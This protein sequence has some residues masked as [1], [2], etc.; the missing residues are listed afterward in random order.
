[1]KNSLLWLLPLALGAA[2][3]VGTA[4]AGVTVPSW[5]FLSCDDL[6]NEY[7]NAGGVLRPFPEATDGYDVTINPATGNIFA[8]DPTNDR[9][10]AINNDNGSVYAISNSVFNQPHDLA[11]HPT[12][13]MLYATN[14]GAN[15]I[16][17]MWVELSGLPMSVV[18]VS[19]SVIGQPEPGPGWS[20]L[21][22]PSG[23]AFDGCGT[24]YV[25]SGADEIV[26]LEPGGSYDYS[27]TMYPTGLSDPGGLAYYDGYLYV[28]SKD[29]NSVL[30]VDPTDGSVEYVISDHLTGPT[31]IAVA[32]GN[33][34]G[35][36]V[37]DTS[38]VAVFD[39]ASGEWAG[40]VDV[41]PMTGVEPTGAGSVVIPEPAA[42]ALLGIGL[43]GLA[44]RRK[45]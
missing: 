5:D 35:L 38:G 32:L 4:S 37:A 19:S 21:V 34:P 20:G 42:L 17:E 10:Y 24:M 28:V 29:N 31:S 22:D 33:D 11:F 25:S 9:I 43:G 41:G 27:R 14:R 39:L 12:N 30:K 26:V 8:S 18:F 2:M 1:M 40:T 3:F 15:R 45:K 44:Y 16:V 23:I 36:L 6:L 13:G 7:D